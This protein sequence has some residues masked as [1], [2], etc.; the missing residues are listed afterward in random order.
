MNLF[1]SATRKYQTFP[2]SEWVGVAHSVSRE[3]APIFTVNPHAADIQLL[4][5]SI[6]NPPRRSLSETAAFGR[7]S[8][9]APL[10]YLEMP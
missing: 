7:R 9:F 3:K 1:L 6:G 2:D 5:A 8:P 10:T 4:Q